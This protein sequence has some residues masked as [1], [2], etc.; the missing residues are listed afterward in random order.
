MDFLIPEA[1]GLGVV[2]GL[3]LRRLIGY[4][5]I[6]LVGLGAGVWWAARHAGD[7]EGGTSD[8]FDNQA[9]E[10]LVQTGVMFAVAAGE[11][12]LACWATLALVDYL[13]TT[14]ANRK[15]NRSF[16]TTDHQRPQRPT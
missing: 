12:A 8:I 10:L 15:A 14:R 7:I 6:P 11:A 13:G 16:N 4:L 9:P 2:A 5:T 3:V 1:I